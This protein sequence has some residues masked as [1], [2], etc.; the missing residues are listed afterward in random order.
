[1]GF[2]PRTA[3]VLVLLERVGGSATTTAAL[4]TPVHEDV[5][6]YDSSSI[7]LFFHKNARKTQ[8]T[9]LCREMILLLLLLVRP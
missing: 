4:P 9:D 7:V 1:M 6:R 8:E 3:V 5:L 2:V